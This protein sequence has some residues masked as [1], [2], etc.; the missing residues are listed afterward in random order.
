MSQPDAKP[1]PPKPRENSLASSVL[2][3]WAALLVSLASGFVLPR[4]IGDQLGQ[5]ILGIWDF[6]WSLVAFTS[7]LRI[8]VASSV[9]PY[10]ARYTKLNDLE[11]LN[12]SVNASAL[13][14]TISFGLSLFLLAAFWLVTPR[15]LG[16]DDA[17]HVALARTLIIIL[18]LNAA[19]QMPLGLYSGVL[20]GLR[21]FD[22]K[23]G[24]QSAGDILS[25]VVMV[26]LLYSGAGLPWLAATAL[27]CEL[28]VALINY[29]SCR[30]LCPG[31]SVVPWR[32]DRASVL[33]VLGFGGKSM[34]QHV[35]RVGLY[36]ASGMIVSA[37]MG[38]AALAV[39]SRQRALI[40]YASKLMNQ[41]GAVFAPSASALYAA[42][43]HEGLRRLA[44]RSTRFGLYF[45]L[46]IVAL[47]AISGG[48]VVRLWM[49]PGY[50][51]P[52]ALALLAAGHL[53]SLS[54]RGAYRILQGMNRHG[55]PAAAECVCAI[56]SIG[57]GIFLVGG[58]GWG[59]SGAAGAVAL[60]VTI[61]GGLA[62][63]WE[64][65]RALH[66]HPVT[67]ARKIGAG[68]LL[69][70]LPIVAAL[71]GAR[72]LFPQHALYELLFGLGVGGVL[73]APGYWFAVA[74]QRW[75]KRLLA[76]LGREAACADGA[77][78]A[79]EAFAAAA[80]GATE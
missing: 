53:V 76:K 59:I 28:L 58:L 57:L 34:L 39:Y 20:N 45:T 9:S 62:P 79:P 40:A 29:V 55:R 21:R 78:P 27:S 37:F 70:V 22:L 14:L 16:S 51:A 44:F 31:L 56:L 60:S 15:L 2:T 52:A 11:G 32:T 65:C 26:T 49:G 36:Q 66:I 72:W 24:A 73:A 46:P 18:G 38:P 33:D 17:G 80:K 50:E 23:N 47:L 67:Y 10:V 25:V 43:D 75:R 4:L 12:R 71:S 6:G 7:L 77:T 13:A 48:A 3:S 64:V 1:K 30:R 8:G 69:A 35:S 5:E 63:A 61:G 42:G 74:P 41:Y 54:Q 68:P 19:L